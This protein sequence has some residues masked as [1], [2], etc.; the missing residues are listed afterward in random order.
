MTDQLPNSTAGGEPAPVVFRSMAEAM[1]AAPAW[2]MLTRSQ[3]T[4][5]KAIWARQQL[6][7][8]C[9]SGER[10]LGRLVGVSDRQVRRLLDQLCPRFVARRYER[11]QPL[12]LQVRP[13]PDPAS[14]YGKNKPSL[15]GVS[16]GRTSTSKP[17]R[18]SMSGGSGHGC[19]PNNTNTNPNELG[20]H[21]AKREGTL[22]EPA[23]IDLKEMQFRLG[24]TTLCETVVF[25]FEKRQLSKMKLRG[26]RFP[27]PLLLA[28]LSTLGKAQ[29]PTVRMHFPCANL[30]SGVYTLEVWEADL[31]AKEFYP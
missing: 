26:W 3:E 1:A 12:L 5:C 7:G 28:E 23:K 27:R 22:F 19:P 2:A 25:L 21:R 29:M 17:P 18:T 15:S 6:T 31:S 4:L 30:T 13:A 20:G 8:W 24:L 9:F 10:E 11:G 14:V 16:K